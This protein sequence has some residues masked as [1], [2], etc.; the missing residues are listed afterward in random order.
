MP[1]CFVGVQCETSVKLWNVLQNEFTTSWPN[2]SEPQ[3]SAMSTGVMSA[4]THLSPPS[5]GGEGVWACW[6]VRCRQHT[7]RWFEGE[8]WCVLPNVHV[9]HVWAKHNQTVSTLRPYGNIRSHKRPTYC[10]F[11]ETVGQNTWSYLCEHKTV[12]AQ[13]LIT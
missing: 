12:H 1:Q 3:F 11:T 4:S 6:R 9:G 5:I 13:G 10:H 2:V 7:A 8:L